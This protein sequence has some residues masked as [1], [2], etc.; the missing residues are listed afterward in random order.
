[1][2]REHTARVGTTTRCGKCGRSISEK[3]AAENTAEYGSGVE[4]AAPYCSDACDRA[5]RAQEQANI[6]EFEEIYRAG[7]T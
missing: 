2:V 6:E 1:M 3:E 4:I 7:A 5:R